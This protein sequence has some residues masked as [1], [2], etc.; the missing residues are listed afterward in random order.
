MSWAYE[1]IDVHERRSGL[2]GV[3]FGARLG[4]VTALVGPAG[5]GKTAVFRMLAGLERPD[6]GAVLVAGKEISTAKGRALKRIQRRLAVVF[7]GTGGLFAGAT[8]HDN[9]TI[10]MRAA[11]RVP[12]RDVDRVADEELER[13]GLMGHRDH[14]PD[15][16]GRAQAR[17]LALARALVLRSPLVLV[18]GID[19]A[20]DPETARLVGAA[21]QHDAR[22]HGTSWLVTARTADLLSGVADAF[23]GLS[24]GSTRH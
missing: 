11:G 10:A 18:D 7:A 12:K 9:L 20:L 6:E 16:L 24:H 22:E 15:H 19:E 21:V 23:V 2:Q 13:F 1:V 5:A 8:A 4:E 3:D 17:C 14:T